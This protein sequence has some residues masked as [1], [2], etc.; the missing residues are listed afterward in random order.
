MQAVCK[1]L[2]DYTFMGVGFRVA[3]DGLIWFEFKNP[4]YHEISVDPDEI[5][6]YSDDLETYAHGLLM[7]ALL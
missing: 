3:E 6:N 1:V 5:T 7:R 2:N 4:A